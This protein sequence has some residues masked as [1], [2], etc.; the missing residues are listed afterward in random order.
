[1]VHIFLE[2]S[3]CGKYPSP[4]PPQKKR[5]KKIKIKR[6]CGLCGALQRFTDPFLA[7]RVTDRCTG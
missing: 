1:M 3:A 7:L 6:L 4:P 2:T 5:K